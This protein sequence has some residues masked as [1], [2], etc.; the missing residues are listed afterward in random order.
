MPSMLTLVAFAVRQLRTTDWPRSMAGGSAVI[1]AVGAGVL[2]SG[3]MAEGGGAACFLW[4]PAAAK[5]AKVAI[6]AV[7]FQSVVR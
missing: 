1:D 3:A 2:F 7:L 5:S 6:N 4:Q